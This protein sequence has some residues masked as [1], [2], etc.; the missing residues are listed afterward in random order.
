LSFYIG[1]GAE[2]GI[3]PYADLNKDGRVNLIDFSIL[4]FW[5]GKDD[6]CCDQNQDGNVN[7]VDFSIL[8]YYWT[9]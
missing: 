2:Q 8:L 7:I 5:W 4:L 1:E 6:M 9:G 3:C